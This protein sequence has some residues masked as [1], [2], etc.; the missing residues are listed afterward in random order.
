M[1]DFLGQKL[2]LGDTVVYPLG[3]SQMGKG[4]IKR[5]TPKMIDVGYYLKPP[6]IVVKVS[7]LGS[8]G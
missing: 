4:T 1:R 2:S 7:G 3:K 6:S 8:R 5:F